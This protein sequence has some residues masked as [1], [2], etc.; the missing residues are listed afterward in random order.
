M[1]ILRTNV[2]VVNKFLFKF[3]DLFSNKQFSMFQSFVY[4]MLRDYKRLN[5]SS[6]SKQLSSN[7][8]ALQYFFS[9]SNWSY[10]NLNNKRINI[11]KKQRTTGFSKDGVLAIDD[12][13]SLKPR[14]KKT[15]GASFQYFSTLKQQAYCNVAVASCFVKDSKHIPLNFKFYKP[16]DEFRLGKY[17]P[18]FKSKLDFAKELFIE[19][20]DQNINFSYAVFDSWYSSSDFLEFINTKN[21][22][23]ITEIK[24]DRRFLFKNPLSGKYSWLQQDELVKLIKKFFPHKVKVIRYKD[25][26]LPIYSFQT[27][28]KNSSITV[29]A[30]VIFNK[31]SDDDLKNIH[32]L[33]TNDL[34]LSFK[35]APSFYMQ[36]WGIE[37]AF[38]ELKDTFFFDHYQVR[39]KEKIMRY[40][41]L[42]TLVFSL[43]YWIKFN[44]CL[45]KILD[46]YPSSFNEY[47]Q[48]LSKLILFSSC[49]FLSNNP[50]EFSIYFADIKSQRFKSNSAFN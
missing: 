44:G 45:T 33:I 31:W 3:K 43:I 35:K 37:R 15:E 7:Y 30:F 21:R 38:Q 4:A 13:G 29:K 28:L 40:W 5:L 26:F 16:Q 27:R 10:D 50:L 24:A 36:R 14:A 6:L 39:T 47:K 25:S 9:D 41:I 32:I 8:Q 2:S 34:N 18:E 20:I 23:F 19:A 22:Y 11:L 12:T 46:Y 49:S 1:N 42:S 17:D 48:A